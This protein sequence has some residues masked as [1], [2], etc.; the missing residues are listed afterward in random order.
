[1]ARKNRITLIGHVGADPDIQTFASGDKAARISIAT[2]E[3]YTDKQSNQKV[4]VTEWHPI[5]FQ[6]ALADRVQQYVK[7]GDQLYIEG[8]LRTYK[9]VIGDKNVTQH[10]IIATDIQFLSKRRDSDPAH[11]QHNN[12][13]Y[14]PA[15]GSRGQGNPPQNPNQPQQAQQQNQQYG[16]WHSNGAPF[17]QQQAAMANA[18]Q[19]Q[20]WPRGTTPPQQAYA[21]QG[22]Y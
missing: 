9:I 16:Y 18:Q 10:K 22:V 7:K 14:Q 4:D 6:A 19:L 5:E 15:P 1:M 21:I 12:G 11:G 8:K 13:G 3:S 2:D 20:T 17:N